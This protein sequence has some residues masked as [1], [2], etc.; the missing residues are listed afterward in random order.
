MIEDGAEVTSSLTQTD[1]IMIFLIIILA[2]L[3]FGVVWII[4][5]LFKFIDEKN[6]YY[7]NLNKK[8]KDE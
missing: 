3:I 2:L 1:G 7:Q 8:L 5:I 4:M 6:K